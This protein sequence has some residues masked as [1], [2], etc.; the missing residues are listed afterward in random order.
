MPEAL[1]RPYGSRW[2]VFCRGRVHPAP[3]Q[4][5]VTPIR[6]SLRQAMWRPFQLVSRDDQGKAVGDEQGVDDFEG[7]PV[8]EMFL[9]VQSITPPPNAI[10]PALST[11][12]RGAIRCSSIRPEIHPPPESGHM[13]RFAPWPVFTLAPPGF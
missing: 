6:R 10:D 1:C 13:V 4:S 5:K 8:S 2:C 9:T 11:R 12:R 7:G 3:P